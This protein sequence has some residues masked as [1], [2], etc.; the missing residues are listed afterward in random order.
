PQADL[1]VASAVRAGTWANP[2]RPVRLTTPI[3]A[4]WTQAGA[5]HGE[6]Q[7]L[8]AID[9]EHVTRSPPAGRQ[10]SDLQHAPP[11][12]TGNRLWHSK[13][14]YDRLSVWRPKHSSGGHS[15]NRPRRSEFPHWG[16]AR[17]YQ[18]RAQRLYPRL[19]RWQASS[20]A[21]SQ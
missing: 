3:P 6:V 5:L 12:Q 13:R 17:C 11:I 14:Q 9:A 4:L 15:T 2:S 7:G 16:R 8:Q 21:V 1:A 18:G 10:A 19:I 20:V